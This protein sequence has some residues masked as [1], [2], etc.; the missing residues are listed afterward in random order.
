MFPLT[1]GTGSGQVMGPNPF[2]RV[3]QGMP[4]NPQV[5]PMS[6]MPIM[7]PPPQMPQVMPQFQVPPM[8]NPLPGMNVQAPQMTPPAMGQENMLQGLSGH[9][10]GLDQLLMQ[11]R[12]GR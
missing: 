10:P 4:M 5:P 11:I 7:R 2:I 6:N 3:P 8:P 1:P 12:G 9:I